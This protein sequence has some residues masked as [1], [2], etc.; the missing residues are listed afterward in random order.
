MAK[1][2]VMLRLNGDV[3]ITEF[4]VAMTHF[5]GLMNALSDE[6]AGSMDVDWEI[7][8]LEAGSANIGLIGIA[9]QDEII[10]K[11]VVG[12]GIVGSALQTNSPIPY[13]TEVVEQA[14][15]L[16]SIINGRVASMSFEIEGQITEVREAVVR[17]DLIEGKTYA[18]GTITGIARSLMRTPFR[19]SIEDELFER[20]VWC[21]TPASYEEMMREAWG[22]RVSVTGLIYRDP[23]TGRPETVKSVVH[24]EIIEEKPPLE[25]FEA[26]RGVLPWNETDESSEIRVRQLRDDEL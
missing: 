11:I 9:E 3:P 13:S 19:I 2:T 23:D 10:E 24:L 15:G 18:L 21:Y 1:N 8:E 20:A 26:A 25:G 7:K 5:A 12:Y 16:V 17:D 22:K 4:A 14:H 6:I